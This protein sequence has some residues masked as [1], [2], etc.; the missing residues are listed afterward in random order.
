MES[1]KAF[2]LQT[3]AIPFQQ[4]SHHWSLAANLDWTSGAIAATKG[5][6]GHSQSRN[7][8]CD[9]QNPDKN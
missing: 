2:A 6:D 3:S 8:R 9:N 1:N 7:R 5:T 4:C